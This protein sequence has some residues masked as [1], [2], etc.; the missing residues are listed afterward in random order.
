MKKQGFTLVEILIALA[1]LVTG[2]IGIINLFPVGLDAT[3]KAVD[4][5]NVSIV[6]QRC[7]EEI[8][9]AGFDAY[10]DEY[11]SPAGLKYA[12][13]PGYEC[14]IKVNNHTVQNLKIITVTVKWSYRGNPKEDKFVTYLA[15]YAP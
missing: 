3:K 13:Y 8:K 1:I 4:I 11:T 14:Y 5:S 12:E 6:A 7:L 9:T 10:P 15:K 2:I